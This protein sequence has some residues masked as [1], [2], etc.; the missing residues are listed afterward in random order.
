[1]AERSEV[2]QPGWEDHRDNGLW[3]EGVGQCGEVSARQQR[4]NRPWEPLWEAWL[5]VDREVHMFEVVPEKG[6]RQ[7]VDLLARFL[8]AGHRLGEGEGG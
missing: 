4:V 6:S 8:Y 7:S 1:M 3:E 5:L 2:V